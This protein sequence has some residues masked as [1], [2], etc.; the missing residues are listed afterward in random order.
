MNSAVFEAIFKDDRQ[1]LKALLTDADRQQVFR[2]QSPL[3]FAITLGRKECVELLLANPGTNVL[4]KNSQLWS[5]FNEA[6]SMGDRDIVRMVY[7]A[8]RAQLD[9][10]F[11]EKGAKLLQELSSVRS[12]IHLIAFSIQNLVPSS[13]FHLILQTGP[14]RLHPGYDV[15]V[16]VVDS[17]CLGSLSLRHLQNLQAWHQRTH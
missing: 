4:A 1:A 16:P 7:M 12:P 15:E 13:F 14:P 6:V 9:K 10:W 8:R 17:V 11:Q 2:G 5:P 3:S